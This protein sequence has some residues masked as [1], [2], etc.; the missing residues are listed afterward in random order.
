MKS[1]QSL[2]TSVLD[3]ELQRAHVL[4]GEETVLLQQS[5]TILYF[6]VFT[7]TVNEHEQSEHQQLDVTSFHIDRKNN[8]SSILLSLFFEV[9][10]WLSPR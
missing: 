9:E 7:I 8:E 2:L 4:K 5:E 3:E 10:D 1:H 6:F